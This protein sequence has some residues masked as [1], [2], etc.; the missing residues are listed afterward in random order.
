MQNSCN[1]RARV[2]ARDPP[3]HIFHKRKHFIFHLPFLPSRS[4]RQKV[5]E[6]VQQKRNYLGRFSKNVGDFL[7]NV[8][9]FSKNVGDFQRS[10]RRY[11]YPIQH[12]PQ[13]ASIFSFTAGHYCCCRQWFP[14][15]TGL[16]FRFRTTT[17]TLQNKRIHNRTSCLK[18]QK[19]RV[20]QNLTHPLS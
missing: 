8:G 11:L 6:K 20:C 18:A 7:K 14:F 9:A 1:A 12:I 10:L 3:T 15:K 5:R 13:S 17:F 16:V 19:K 4:L 2:R